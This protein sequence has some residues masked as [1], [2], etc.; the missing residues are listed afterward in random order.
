MICRGWL[1]FL[2]LVSGNLVLALADASTAGGRLFAPHR[3]IYWA[4]AGIA[5]GALALILFVPSLASV[6]RVAPAAPGLLGLA[7]LAGL[8]GGGWFGVARAVV[9]RRRGETSAASL[10]PSRR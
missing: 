10:G 8:G 1:F 4:I 2:A 5:G 3:R 6:F 9:G 7:L